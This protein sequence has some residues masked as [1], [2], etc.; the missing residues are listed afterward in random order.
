[1]FEMFEENLFTEELGR[2]R[3]YGIRSDEETIS[4]VWPESRKLKRFLDK[5]NRS[6]LSSIHLY[7]AVMD[8]LCD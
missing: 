7:D 1:M 5:L 2:Y 4:D 3:S 8:F 6:G